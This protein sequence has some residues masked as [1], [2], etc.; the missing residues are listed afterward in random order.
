MGDWNVEVDQE[1]N[2]LYV[3]MSGEMTVEEAEAN[4]QAT[5]D[6]LEKLDEGF[7]VV[8][9][10]RGIVVNEDE[11]LEFLETG[12][13]RIN[14]AGASAAVRVEPDSTTAQM[15]FERVGEDKEGYAVAQADSL[16][17]AEKLLDKRRDE[18][19]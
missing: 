17:T 7:D 8:T 1:K 18:D 6:A 19:L 3:D 9:D 14:D 11:V 4:Q 5:V 16:E 12:K 15:Q 2:R 13:R 10:L